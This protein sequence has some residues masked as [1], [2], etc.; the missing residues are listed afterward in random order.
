MLR[1]KKIVSSPVHDL[2]N[3]LNIP[4]YFPENAK[5][6]Q[7][8]SELES[9]KVDMCI[10]AAYGNFLPKRY[11]YVYVCMSLLCKQKKSYFTI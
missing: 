8:L 6:E 4:I 5:D 9:L 11:P 3:E 1:A 10:T 7:F 2:S